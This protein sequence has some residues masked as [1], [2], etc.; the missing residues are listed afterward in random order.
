MPK[1]LAVL[2]VRPLKMRFK[3]RTKIVKCN[4]KVRGDNVAIT[5]AVGALLTGFVVNRLDVWS[6]IKDEWLG[7]EQWLF[8]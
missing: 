7:L 5:S 6:D 1:L 3:N 4:P 8:K 2:G